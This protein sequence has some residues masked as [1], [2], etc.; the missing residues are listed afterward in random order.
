MVQVHQNR[1]RIAVHVRDFPRADCAFNVR[2]R[3]LGLGTPVKDVAPRAAGGHEQLARGKHL[4]LGDDPRIGA[5]QRIDRHDFGFDHL[6]IELEDF[7]NAVACQVERAAVGDQLGGRAIGEQQTEAFD[8]GAAA[9]RHAH[10]HEQGIFAGLFLGLDRAVQ[11]GIPVGGLL[12]RN[13]GFGEHVIAEIELL[14][15]QHRRHR[16]NN[17]VG[18]GQFASDREHV[19]PSVGAFHLCGDIDQIAS[20]R[21]VH[22]LSRRGQRKDVRTGAS[23]Q[24]GQ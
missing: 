1:R 17:A 10:R 13:A 14:H 9:P 4:V 18:L 15:R 7:A 16:I 8:I 19:V 3:V 12:C 11:Q 5:E 21:E 6:L 22:D 20:G 24:F 23:A 2:D